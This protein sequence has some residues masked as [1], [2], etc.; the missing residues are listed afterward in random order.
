MADLNAADVSDVKAFFKMYYAPNN[1]VLSVVGDFKTAECLEKIRTYFERIPSQPAPPVVDVTEPVQTE[2]RRMTLED[3]LARTARVDIA[4]HT[5]P[6][7][8]PDDD[9]L[10]VLGSILSSGRSSRLYDSLVRD[11]QLTAGVFASPTSMRGPSLFQAGGTVLV[12]KSVADLEN[13]IYAEIEKVKSGPIADWEIEKARNN[14]RRAFISGLGSSLQRAV[15][16][17]QYALF[18]NDPNLVNTRADRIAKVTIAD[19][20]RVARQY[21]TQT[22]RNVIVTNP[23]A[24]TSGQGGR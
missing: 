19:V 17:G 3:A 12:G 6:G 2:E 9:A 10:S 15:V 20:Q 21:L 7:N 18:W 11:K 13:G 1:A 8:T 23:K 5:P 24:A 4:W 16:L 22:N 14:Q